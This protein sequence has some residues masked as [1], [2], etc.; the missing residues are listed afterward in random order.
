MAISDY[1][2]RIMPSYTER[3]SAKKLAYK[4]AV[5]LTNTSDPMLKGEVCNHIVRTRFCSCLDLDDVA[6]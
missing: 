1:K 6:I 5:L 2:Q 4:E 3:G